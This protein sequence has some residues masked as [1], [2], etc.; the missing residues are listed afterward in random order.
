[1]SPDP[2][3]PVTPVATVPSPP[4]SS[5]GWSFSVWL[6]KN[7]NMLKQG[8][9]YITAAFTG[10]IGMIHIVPSGPWAV[11]VTAGVGVATVAVQLGSRFALDWIDYR[12]S[13]GPK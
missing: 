11:I 6:T 13:D 3:V 2:V 5:A 10:L 9:S 12:Y 8:I 4:G 7:K 1:M